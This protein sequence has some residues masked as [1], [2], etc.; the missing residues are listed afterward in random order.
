MFAIKFNFKP[1][2][3]DFSLTRGLVINYGGEKVKMF[4]Q[5]L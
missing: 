1:R 4:S 3:A 5:S 2:F